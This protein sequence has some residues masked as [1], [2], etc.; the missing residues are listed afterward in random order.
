MLKDS[1]FTVIGSR[2]QLHDLIGAGGMGAVYR[3]YDRLTGQMVAL[4]RVTVPTEQL[5]FA[6]R[7]DS[8][9]ELPMALTNEF[10]LLASLRHPHIISVLD[11]G[12]DEQRNPFF[13]MT[14]LDNPQTIT[15]A[16]QGNT[17]QAKV[18]LLVQTLQ[19]LNYLHRRDIMHRDL[20]P[21][22]VLVVDGQVRVLDF[23]L[24][25][26]HD[27]PEADMIVGTLP[28]MAP[29][30]I[31]GFAITP[32]AD[33][34][35]VGIM[36]YEMLAGRH[37]FTASSVS[38]MIYDTIH[39]PV[40]LQALDCSAPL[41]PIIGRLL[42]KTPEDRY[43]SAQA[44]ITA[45]NEATDL[46]TSETIAIRESFLQAAR[47]VGRDAEY[48]QL[49][50][51][52]NDALEGA[53]SAW[54]V[55]GE[56]GVGKSRLLSELRTLALVK[57]ALV[58]SGQAI[59]EGGSLYQLWRDALR[60]MVLYA[61]ITPP[62][63]SILKLLIPDIGALL[64]QD[65]PDAPSVDAQAMQERLL[66]TIENLFRRQQHP[67]V[68]ILEDLH[69]TGESLDV[70]VRL[71]R[72]VSQLPLFILASYRDEERPDL[73]RLLP[74]MRLLK[75]NRLP[76]DS[77]AELS[78]SMLGEAGQ[79]PDVLD[80]LQRET[81]G[82]VFFLV[83][84][85]RALA[86]EAGELEKVG[87]MALPQ[88]VM[89]G[90]IQRIIQRR[91][92][93]V[94]EMARH[95]LEVAAV[96]GR[97]LDLDILRAIAPDTN[98][99]QWLTTCADAAILEVYSDKWRFAHDRLREGLLAELPAD[100]RQNLHRQV[101]QGIESVYR[102]T[103][104]APFY[105]TLAHHWSSAKETSKAMDYL[106]KAGI[107]A[108]ENF[109]NRE[110]ADYFRQLLALDNGART[111]DAVQR[112][113]WWKRLLAQAQWGLGNLSELRREVEEAFSIIGRPIPTNSMQLNMGLL[114]Q[115]GV[116]VAHRL[117]PIRRDQ[118]RERVLLEMVRGYKLL[119]QAYFFL[120]E[121]MLT[122]YVTL[123]EMNLAER[124][125]PSPELAE[126]YASMCLVA[127]LMPMH[128]L[129]EMYARRSLAIA[130]G[131]NTWILAQVKSVMSLYYTG[132]GNWEKARSYID[133]SIDSA[134]ELGDRR[135][136]ESASGVSAILHNF[137]G[138]LNRAIEVFRGVYESSQK[139]GNIQTYA[140]SLLGQAENLLP[141]GEIE[142][143]LNYALEAE[144]LLTNPL[145][146]PN[147][148]RNY[149][150]LALAYFRLGE[151]Q[152]ALQA[153]E[154]TS[155]LIAQAPPTASYIL[156]H[157]AAIAE[158]YLHLWENGSAQLSTPRE[159]F[160]PAA[161]QACKA[162]NQFAH[163]FP[164]GKA[165]AGIYQ[166]WC[167]WLSGN[168]DKARKL[169]QDSA[170]TARQYGM[171]MDEA[172]AWYEHARHLPENDAER[173]AYLNR[174]CE[175]FLAMNATYHYNCAQGHKV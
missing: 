111:L 151:H 82:N 92:N 16:A 129:A 78:A 24:S 31:Q 154:K 125:A 35:A 8:S 10:R 76:P 65:I 22:N 19:A 100:R 108:L 71:T 102:E 27:Q 119:G 79:R 110:A 59:S 66:T 173:D 57:G 171:P 116:Q 37:P 93:R 146:Q 52:L 133:Y 144:T 3:A 101:A 43:P 97:Q 69:W 135:M 45:L 5:Q 149:A 74:N 164:I 26:I 47:F 152:L 159:A 99:D 83:E 155:Q 139:S 25:V 174:A 38:K 2:Y 72:I 94:P 36:A 23:G 13:T 103:G 138:D 115:A 161:R 157:Y 55:G 143:A 73:P 4:K 158:I 67:I 60:R 150:L 147:E 63:A 132:V 15:E 95:L 122:I 169:W 142:A 89:A 118:R 130:E 7:A 18:N 48:D 156:H 6:S 112:R 117:L 136:W 64:G 128:S 14:L 106:E 29:E 49:A 124:V 140:W 107:Q 134:D 120:N 88:Q 85:V 145:G 53:G 44:V 33:L 1:V 68:L 163:V 113:A 58:L 34:Y 40:D 153:A 148:V 121:P 90:G 21:G 127:G 141:L 98:L 104:L 39:M 84:I 114:K 80:F 87:V 28:Y 162:L 86:E 56:S 123:Q 109:A 9:T 75:L 91:L 96:A 131:L 42:A 160:A 81:E 77:V 170:A 20:K 51:A 30:S 61:D 54:L 167:E 166:G 168:Q 11:Y 175:R 172:L 32:S 12:F 46:D 137:H 126:A 62:E 50:D 105:T 41:K 165:R 17:E 70:L